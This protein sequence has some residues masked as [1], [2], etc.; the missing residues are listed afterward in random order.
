VHGYESSARYEPEP[1]DPAGQAADHGGS[2]NLL[3][4]KRSQLKRGHSMGSSNALVQVRLE[5]HSIHV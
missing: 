1:P 2:L 3:S 5:E 4:S